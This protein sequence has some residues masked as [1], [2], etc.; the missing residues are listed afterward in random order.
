MGNRKRW[1]EVKLNDAYKKRLS[2]RDAGEL[3]DIAVLNKLNGLKRVAYLQ[4]EIADRLDAMMCEIGTVELH[5]GF[6]ASRFKL[7]EKE[8]GEL[9]S[10]LA[11]LSTVFPDIAA[12]HRMAADNADKIVGQLEFCKSKLAAL[13][14][15]LRSHRE[16][17]A[18][19]FTN[20]KKGD[21]L[22]GEEDVG[23]VRGG[24]ESMS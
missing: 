15:S 6:T 20:S 11:T 1:R 18:R 21:A 4:K 23:K 10:M 14:A 24:V 17:I 7:Q 3:L 19:L 22:Y 2:K 16:N 9:T 13:K 5:M 8:R 12:E